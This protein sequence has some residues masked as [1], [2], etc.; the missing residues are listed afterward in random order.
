MQDLHQAF[1]G[2]W[3]DGYDQQIDA[4][5][6]AEG[7]ELVKGAKAG[8]GAAGRTVAFAHAVVEDAENTQMAVFAVAQGRDEVVSILA[9]ADDHGAAD[10]AAGARQA[11]DRFTRDP[12]DDGHGGQGDGDPAGKLARGV[13]SYVQQVGEPCDR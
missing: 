6:T 4:F 2:A 11:F 1:F 8:D 9:A 7:G 12:A 5:V 10:E 3:R 13:S